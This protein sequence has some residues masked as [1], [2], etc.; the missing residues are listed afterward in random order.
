MDQYTHQ[1]LAAGSHTE[2]WNIAGY[3]FIAAG[4]GLLAYVGITKTVN[5]YRVWL[6]REPE[7]ET[8]VPR[9]FASAP[10]SSAVEIDADPAQ[11]K[12]AAPD[13]T[14]AT[15]EATTETPAPP[16]AET[17]RTRTRTHPPGPPRNPQPQTRRSHG[18]AHSESPPGSPSRTT[19]RPRRR[20]RRRPRHGTEGQVTNPIRVSAAGGAGT[21]EAA[22]RTAKPGA[23]LVLEAGE[24][25]ENLRLDKP[26]SLA[27]AAGVRAEQVVI[28]AAKADRAVLT[29]AADVRLWGVTID[30]EATTGVAVSVTAGAF[31]LG[32]CN[33]RKGRVE[34]S[35]G[36]AAVLRDCTISESPA[37]GVLAA[38]QSQLTLERCQIRD[39][40]GLGIAGVD[41]TI[42]RITDSG[43]TGSVGI[44]LR[45]LGKASAQAT[46]ANF[47]HVSEAAVQVE[48][49]SRLTMS[50]SRI[51]GT[52]RTGVFAGGTTTL[53]L[54][55]GEIAKTGG[56]GIAYRQQAHG[57]VSGTTIRDCAGN[58]LIAGGDTEVTL[59][60]CR[61]ERSAFSAYH[62]D[63]RA[64]L[65]AEAATSETPRSTASWRRAV[66]CCASTAARC[67]ALR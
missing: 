12:P 64:L 23:V 44:G 11:D 43:V 37:V 4:V 38:D 29:V 67:P 65:T 60:G 61:V 66:P 59:A 36:S 54:T 41:D 8:F 42:L 31:E 32:R 55:D 19:P 25:H 18:D 24:Y 51:T 14:E 40:A 1:Y 3:V 45:L 35:G 22:L 27:A 21:I 63:D 52:G 13:A 57:S 2:P 48:G 5:W 47:E 49:A 56:S 39:S 50:G 26:I 33:I 17:T 46:S 28:R 62:A 53:N 20:Q 15:D 6:G 34:A 58:G 16:T 30:A 9:E 10:E 7:D